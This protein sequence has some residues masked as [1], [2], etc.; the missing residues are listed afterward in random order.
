MKK[1]NFK[2]IK[3]GMSRNEMRTIKGAGCGCLDRCNPGGCGGN[4]GVCRAYA[5]GNYCFSS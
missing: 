3:N 2:D 1:L 4:C 5:G